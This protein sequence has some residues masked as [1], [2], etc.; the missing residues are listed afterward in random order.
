MGPANSSYFQECIDAGLRIFLRKG[1]FIHSKTFVSDDYISSIGT[2]NVDFRSFDINYEVNT[3]IY[4]DETAIL[5]KAIFLKDLELCEEV[6]SEIWKTRSWFI[7]T[8]EQILRLFSPL[9]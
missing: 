2:A 3:Y 8:A 7:R 4:D 5:N 9:L 1:E 6:T